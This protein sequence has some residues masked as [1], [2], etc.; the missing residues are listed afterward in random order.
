MIDYPGAEHFPPVAEHF[1]ED[2]L[3]SL[4]SDPA[5]VLMKN[6]TPEFC[7]NRFY[8]NCA[9]ADFEHELRT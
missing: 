9:A 7:K 2:E 4:A 8:R 6:E 3:F 1:P 5:L